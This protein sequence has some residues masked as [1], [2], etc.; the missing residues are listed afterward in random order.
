MNKLAKSIKVSLVRESFFQMM[1]SDIYIYIERERER[2]NRCTST[3]VHTHT[4]MLTMNVQK[5]DY[6]NMK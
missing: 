1:N 4:H 3:C 6:I 5:F 2:D